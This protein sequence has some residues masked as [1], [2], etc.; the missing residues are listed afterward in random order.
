M[1]RLACFLLEGLVE[2]GPHRVWVTLGTFDSQDAAQHATLSARSPS[3]IDTRVIALYRD[4][5]VTSAS[6]QRAHF[7]NAAATQPDNSTGY[8]VA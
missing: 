5:G 8:T 1:K 4:S 7:S 2:Q 6:S 3:V